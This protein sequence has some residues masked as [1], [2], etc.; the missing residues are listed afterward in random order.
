EETDQIFRPLAEKGAEGTGSMGDDTPIAVLSRHVRPLHDYFRQQFAQ[1]TNPPIDRLRESIVMSLETRMGR[2]LNI[3]E[4][5]AEHAD[6]IILHSPLLSPR[7]FWSLR[8]LNRSGY[9]SADLPLDYDPA[10]GLEQAICNVVA[11]AEA[12]A[13]AGKVLLFIS[14]RMPPH[15]RL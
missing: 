9:D 5:T 1:V 13:R 2:E 4:E 6:R 14:E 8:H 10:I 11:R 7:K 12:V 3:F 15:G